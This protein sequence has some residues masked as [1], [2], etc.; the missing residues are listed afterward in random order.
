MCKWR[1]S[2]RSYEQNNINKNIFRREGKQKVEFALENRFVCLRGDYE[3]NKVFP[4]RNEMRWSF[5]SSELSWIIIRMSRSRRNTRKRG[6]VLYFLI[7]FDAKSSHT[8]VSLSSRC[9]AQSIYIKQSPIHNKQIVIESPKLIIDVF[10][11]ILTHLEFLLL[12]YWTTVVNNNK[13]EDK[14]NERNSENVSDDRQQQFSPA[15]YDA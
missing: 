15:S 8:Q 2:T 10:I 9:G 12:H 11:W 14:K 5:I 1:A 3:Q 6:F 7:F 13:E 4:L